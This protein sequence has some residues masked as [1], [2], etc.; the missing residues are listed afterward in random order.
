MFDDQHDCEASVSSN[1]LN[2]KPA[3]M[4]VALSATAGILSALAPL[5]ITETAF[6]LSE[7]RLVSYRQEFAQDSRCPLLFVLVLELLIWTSS[8]RSSVAW[9]QAYLLRLLLR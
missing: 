8:F 4:R 9:V 7:Y 2:R 1:M 3:R 5:L 6:L